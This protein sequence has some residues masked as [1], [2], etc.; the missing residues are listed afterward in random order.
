M[1]IWLTWTYEV[2]SVFEYE[3]LLDYL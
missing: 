1:G 2:F 3:A